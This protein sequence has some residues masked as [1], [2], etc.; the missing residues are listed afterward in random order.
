MC[1][2]GYCWLCP[3]PRRAALP[4]ICR[5]VSDTNRAMPHKPAD[6]CGSRRHH[7]VYVH[8]WHHVATRDD[9]RRARPGGDD[10]ARVGACAVVA[11]G[12]LSGSRRRNSAGTEKGTRRGNGDGARN[13]IASSVARA[14]VSLVKLASSAHVH[15]HN[16]RSRSR[17]Q[18]YVRHDGIDHPAAAH[19]LLGLLREAPV[20]KENW[21]GWKGE[22]HRRGAGWAHTYAA[23]PLIIPQ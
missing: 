8:V 14:T 4:S 19:R 2:C 5:V 22:W 21:G 7:A 23:S 6:R 3:R 11:S 16:E 9:G 17:R 1:R 12:P 13:R 20:V 10:N 18:L 15:A